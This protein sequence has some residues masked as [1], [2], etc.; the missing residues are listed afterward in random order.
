MDFLTLV[1]KM[2]GSISFG[3]DEAEYVMR[4]I[5]EGNCESYIGGRT[6]SQKDLLAGY[7]WPTLEQ[8]ATRLIT[9]C[10]SCQKHLQLSQ[11]LVEFLKVKTTLCPFEQWRLDIMG[12][13]L[14][15]LSQNKF[16]L[17]AMDYF[18]K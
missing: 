9:T 6:L 10:L 15:E 13:F 2:F 1:V 17:V 3:L 14:V 7:F 8:D 16:L 5:H 11:H 18:S 4:E 12:P